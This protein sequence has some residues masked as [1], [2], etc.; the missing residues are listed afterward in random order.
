MAKLETIHE[1]TEEQGIDIIENKKPLGRLIAIDKYNNHTAIDN[2]TG[3]CWTE[4]FPCWDDCIE[5]FD[6]VIIEVKNENK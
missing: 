3:E 2:L 6:S 5:W 4:Y 1:I